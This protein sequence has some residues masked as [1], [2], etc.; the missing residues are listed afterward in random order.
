MTCV[1][2]KESQE[3]NL[4]FNLLSNPGG[5]SVPLIQKFPFTP[6]MRMKTVIYH[7]GGNATLVKTPK[8]CHQRKFDL[9]S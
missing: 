4:L 6:R 5:E 3:C 2:Q 1:S 9:L 8:S 7:R